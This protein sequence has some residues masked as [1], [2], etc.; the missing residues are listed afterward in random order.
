VILRAL[1]LTLS[2]LVP[3]SV[4][5][6][7]EATAARDEEARSIFEAGAT[8]FSA[9]RFEAALRRFREAYELSGRQVLLFNIGTA[10][11]RMRHDQEALESYRAYLEAE[12]TGQHADIARERIAF[13]ETQAGAAPDGPAITVAETGGDEDGGGSVVEEWWFW[14]LI[15]VVVVGAGVGITLGVVLGGGGQVDDP[16]PGTVGGV[17]ITLGAP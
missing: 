2:L 1:A 6:A 17:I 14:T 11:D 8:A 3:V 15:G 16:L 7:Q 10:A 13:L 5:V 12:P 4:C 9:G